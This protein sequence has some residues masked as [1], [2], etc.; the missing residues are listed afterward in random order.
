MKSA[1]KIILAYGDNPSKFK[2]TI[3]Q[4]EVNH[5]LQKLIDKENIYAFSYQG[6][7]ELSKQGNPYHP[8]RK[9][10]NGVIRIKVVEKQS[11]MF[12]LPVT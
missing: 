11:K 10:I 12:L 8:G 1:D 4:K 7:D 6:K 9:R 2:K 5:L 3:H